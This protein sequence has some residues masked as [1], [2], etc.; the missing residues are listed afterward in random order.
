MRERGRLGPLGGPLGVRPQ[1]AAARKNRSFRARDLNAASTRQGLQADGRGA[2]RA[3]VVQAAVTADERAPARYGALA[4]YPRSL[5]S[6]AHRP[7]GDRSRSSPTASRSPTTGRT[8]YQPDSDGYPLARKA[9]LPPDDRIRPQSARR[10]TS[11]MATEGWSGLDRLGVSSDD[12]IGPEGAATTGDSACALA[13]TAVNA[14]HWSRCA[15]ARLPPAR[16]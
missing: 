3:A 6:R 5:E 16:R 11:P 8:P 13:A 2:R 10:P 14:F 12:R 4:T 1:R 7:R 15:G 9:R